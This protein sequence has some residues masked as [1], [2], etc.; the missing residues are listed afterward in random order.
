V[1]FDRIVIR[2]RIVPGLQW[3]KCSHHSIRGLIESNWSAT[4]TTLQFE[5]VIP[6]DA[7]AL[8][9]LPA[10]PGDVLSEGGRAI[11]DIE[12]IEILAPGPESHRFQVGSGR[13]RFT[14]IHRP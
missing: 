13:Y 12:D 2:P 5:I 9:E 4:P 3:V 7:S 8:V 10:R 6:P 14:V 1:G 11:P